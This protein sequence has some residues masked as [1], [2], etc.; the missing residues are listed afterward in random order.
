MGRHG[1]TVE[2]ENDRVRVVRVKA[3]GRGPIAHESRPDR[4]V[5]YLRDAHVRRSE[6][7]ATEELHHKVGDIVW[8]ASS[9]HDVESLADSPHEVLVIELKR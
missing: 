9:K 3:D 4:L 5:V 8:R 2:F 6:A 7:G 1:A